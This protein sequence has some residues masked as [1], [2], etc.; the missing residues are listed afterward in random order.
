MPTTILLV[1][2]GETDW[3]RERRVQGH[4]DRPLNEHGRAQA[5]ALADE[6]ADEPLDAVY[7][8]DLARAY[9]TARAVAERHGLE[10]TVARELRER[11]FGTWEGLLD[12]EILARF[13][14]AHEGPW[15]DDET[16]EQMSERV[17]AALERIAAAHPGGQV[18]VVAHGGPL[19]AAMRRC[20]V[21][22]DGPLANCHVLRL[23]AEGATLRSLD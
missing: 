3:N 15:G 10:V 12:T 9:E 22:P 4:A 8:S 17:A 1:R 7:S 20:G 11:N 21:A 18:L 13:P 5:A 16:Q 14:E 19:R 23:E 6:L 2:H